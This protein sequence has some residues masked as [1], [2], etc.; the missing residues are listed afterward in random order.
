MS[1]EVETLQFNIPKIMLLLQTLSDNLWE[2]KCDN[3]KGHPDKCTCG[4]FTMASA[5]QKELTPVVTVISNM[6]TALSRARRDAEILSLAL[7]QKEEE[8]EVERMF[9][10]KFKSD[11]DMTAV[12]ENGWNRTFHGLP[13]NDF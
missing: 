12:P 13:L 10:E 7:E 11:L 2:T 9:A 1:A 8:L 3:T 4:M 6:S 5:L